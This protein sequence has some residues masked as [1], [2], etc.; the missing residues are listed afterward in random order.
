MSRSPIRCPRVGQYTID[1][2]Y[3]YIQYQPGQKIAYRLYG[4][5][6]GKGAPVICIHGAGSYSY[7]FD[8]MAPELAMKSDRVVISFDFLDFGDSS[9]SQPDAVQNMDYFCDQIN[10]LISGLHD[11]IWGADNDDDVDFEVIGHSTGGCVATAYAHRYPER[12]LSLVLMSPAGLHKSPLI[13]KAIRK[14]GFIGSTMRGVAKRMFG[15]TKQMKLWKDGFYEREKKLRKSEKKEDLTTLRY[16]EDMLACQLAQYDKGSQYRTGL[17]RTLSHLELDKKVNKPA[18]EDVG[19]YNR[20]VLILWGERDGII[21][22]SDATRWLELMPDADLEMISDG[23]HLFMLER[24]R[25][26]N[27]IIVDYFGS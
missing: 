21:P 20:P 17:V 5:K 6:H 25:E 23:G 14:E 3:G 19:K 1:I 4:H 7:V 24:A 15:Q 22:A 27:D 11:R 8:L 2:K 18:I 13:L 26:C 16:F 12:V 9:P 10:A